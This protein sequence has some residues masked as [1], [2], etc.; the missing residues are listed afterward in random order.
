M[1]TIS[2]HA[3]TVVERNGRNIRVEIYI[4]NRLV[5]LLGSCGKVAA[6]MASTVYRLSAT[7]KLQAPFFQFFAITLETVV[8][9][10]QSTA[11]FEDLDVA[12]KP[13]GEPDASTGTSNA[14]VPPTPSSAE[15]RLQSPVAAE[16]SSRGRNRCCCVGLCRSGERRSLALSSPVLGTT[17]DHMA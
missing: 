17:P 5:L 7:M 16:G 15:P 13:Q 6:E 1:L 14:Q 10:A 11:A 8:A 12:A 4:T 2:A 3:R 9:Q